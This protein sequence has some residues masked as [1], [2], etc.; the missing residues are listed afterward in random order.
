MN[1]INWVKIDSSKFDK[2]Y[3][4]SNYEIFSWINKEDENKLDLIN[5]Y[6]N[7]SDAS[8]TTGIARQTI[9]KVCNGICNTA[10]G[11]FWKKI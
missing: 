8:R 3:Y 10:G 5:T 1:V 7:I 9:S 11:Y 4:H 2:Q 6:K